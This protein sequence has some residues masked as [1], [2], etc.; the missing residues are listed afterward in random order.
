[1]NNIKIFG[2][3]LINKFKS[4]I[5][6]P[7][8]TDEPIDERMIILENK[9]D[10]KFATQNF[11][12]FLS[13]YGLNSFSFSSSFIKLWSN[14]LYLS[15][16]IAQT[17]FFMAFYL[18]PIND[19]K[20][21]LLTGDFTV[22]IQS[23]RKFFLLVLMLMVSYALCSS[24]LF[25]HNTNIKWFEVFKCL[26][27]RIPPKS[28]GMRDKKIAIKMLILTKLGIKFFKIFTFS[29][30]LITICIF[31]Y[32][33]YRNAKIHDEIELLA[34]LFWFP[35]T[36]F[37]VY[38]IGGTVFTSNMCFQ[39]ITFYC[40]IMSRYFNQLI[41]NVKI[42]LGFG[43][44]RFIMKLKIKNLIRNQ[45]EFTTKILEY[46]KFWRKFYLIMMLH[47]FPA[48]VICSQQIFFGNLSFGLRF[49]YMMGC[50]FGIGFIVSSSLFVCLL[51]KEMKIHHH[52]LVQL[53]FDPHLNLDTNT[54]LK[55][56]I[57]CLF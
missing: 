40:Y 30:T 9:I 51:A 54:K 42:E 35:A 12:Y 24:R 48:N 46:N 11:N 36:T 15:Y 1:M 50:L 20:L 45:K 34:C 5:L 32:L 55:V 4:N 19:Y 21:C 43:Y 16:W 27:G 25:N 31:G 6:Y 28:V 57:F 47:L 29:F 49:I 17:K 56:I 18:N 26:D 41:Y 38:F 14:F 22:F 52:K 10:P 3:S 53:Q 2:L 8:L 44:K 23:L 13:F 33:F 37:G 7:Y 39:I